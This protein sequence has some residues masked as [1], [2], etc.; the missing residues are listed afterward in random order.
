MFFLLCL[1]AYFSTQKPILIACYIGFAA[2]GIYFCS[3]LFFEDLIK[4]RPC[5]DYP[6]SELTTARL[7][8]VLYLVFITSVFFS[9]YM[10]VMS[11]VDAWAQDT[12]AWKLA[13]EKERQARKEAEEKRT[14]AELNRRAMLTTKANNLCIKL[15]SLQNKAEKANKA[16]ETFNFIHNT[17]EVTMATCLIDSIAFKYPLKDDLE[18]NNPVYTVRI[19]PS[20]IHSS[21]KGS[22]NAEGINLGLVSISGNSTQ[23]IQ[24]EALKDLP[25]VGKPYKNNDNYWV[26]RLLN[27][28]VLFL[29]NRP[30]FYF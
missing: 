14:A 12:K 7:T 8:Q 21:S 26:V 6:D 10:Q 1:M 2:V 15:Y 20:I 22:F 9:S 29:N 16:Q 5:S 28:Q 17:P 11:W 4:K 25:S 23:Q 24:T 3:R 27:G 30:D 13:Q 18:K 19:P